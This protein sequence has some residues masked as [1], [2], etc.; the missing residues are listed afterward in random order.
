LPEKAS[1]LYLP[2]LPTA[3]AKVSVDDAGRWRVSAN[4]VNF[5][6]NRQLENG[7]EQQLVLSRD[8]PIVFYHAEPEAV[9]FNPVAF[10]VRGGM[11]KIVY[12]DHLKQ[13][14]D[15]VYA[16][17]ENTFPATGNEAFITVFL[18]EAARR[19]TY[20]SV[21]TVPAIQSFRTS[22]AQTYRSAP[23]MGRLDV[24]L[25]TLSAAETAQS[26][27]LSALTRETSPRLL[28]GDPSFRSWLLPSAS[29][30]I[31]AQGSSAADAALSS[32]TL[33]DT[34]GILEGY[35]AW[36]TYVPNA[37]NPFER[38]L[39]RTLDLIGERLIKDNTQSNVFVVNEGEV[40]IEFNLRLGLALSAY[41]DRA[42][43]SNWAGVGHS[44]VLSVLALTDDEGQLPTF[45]T[46]DEAGQIAASSTTEKINAAQLYPFLPLASYY[47]HAVDLG[48]VRPGTW[49]WTASPAVSATF[50]NNVLDISVPLAVGWTHYL[51]VRGVPEFTKIQLRDMDYRS[52]PRFE[53]YNSPG[54]VYSASAQTLLVKL[55][56]RSEDE[57]IRIFY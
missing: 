57:H 39:P 24:A 53:Q 26:A 11:E 51:L 8:D 2:Y 30:L 9:T 1:A 56:H 14:A 25:R 23:F 50:Q 44:L 52:D 17:W 45:L 10:I 55:V 32:I 5:M 43:V 35:A 20:P 34:I 3:F 29:N 4:N 47:P 13:W 21:Q 27:Q 48:S 36:P 40:D 22:P 15:K 46:A 31:K 7:A 18:A 12:E 37:D 6:F 19:G 38:L 42:G 28:T 54:W 16:V 41:G 33:A 49:V